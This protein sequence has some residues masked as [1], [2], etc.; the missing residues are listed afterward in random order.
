V[1]GA[2]RAGGGE[3][4]LRIGFAPYLP[5]ELLLRF[6]DGLKEREPKLRAQVKHVLGFEQVRQLQ[7]GEL[8]LGI[9]ANTKGVPMLQTEPLY[10]GEPVSGFLA[11]DHPL[12]EKAV[13]SP[14][15]LANQTLVMLVGDQLPTNPRVAV[16][17]HGLQQFGYRFRA[18]H[19]ANELRDCFLAVAAGAGIALLPGSVLTDGDAGTTIVRR[20][21]DPPVTWPD[22]VVAWRTHPSGQAK[23]LINEVR[24]L[25]HAL[26]ERRDRG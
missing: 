17:L 21:L 6:L 23:A 20:P 13:L 9:F 5:T 24:E 8:D 26:G 2:R 1:A 15:D 25:A 3:L 19:A 10:P 18:L 16:W 14:D 12:A 7:L 11:R 22:T 4:G